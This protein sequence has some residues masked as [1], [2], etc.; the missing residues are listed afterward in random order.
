M[1]AAG[2][3]PTIACLAHSISVLIKS[4]RLVLHRHI[5]PRGALVL[6]ANEVAD[7]LVL[8]LLHGALVVLRALAEEFLLYEINTCCKRMSVSSGLAGVFERDEGLPLSSA[9]SSFSPCAPPPPAL[10][11]LSPRPPRKPPDPP[12]DFC[13]VL[14]GCWFSLEEELP[15]RALFTKSMVVLRVLGVVSEVKT[16]YWSSLFDGVGTY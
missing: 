5:T 8:G 6:P 15:P 14:E 1:L 10:L 13:S 12:S 11:S 7:L 3:F 4:S 9:S 16:W 2:P